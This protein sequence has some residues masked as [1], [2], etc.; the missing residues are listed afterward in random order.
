ME[1]EGRREWNLESRRFGWWCW[2]NTE[3]NGEKEKKRK[4]FCV[5]EGERKTRLAEIII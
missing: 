3:R 2:K 5:V 4:F 1:G